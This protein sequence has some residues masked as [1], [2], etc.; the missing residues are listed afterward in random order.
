MSVTAYNGSELFLWYKLEPEQPLATGTKPE[1]MGGLGGGRGWRDD[2]PATT[3]VKFLPRTSPVLIP[4]QGYS[5]FF[6]RAQTMVVMDVGLGHDV[7]ML[8][9]TV[10]ERR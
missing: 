2:I 7:S 9:V 1:E 4:S 8:G 6:H 5:L 3:T 10:G